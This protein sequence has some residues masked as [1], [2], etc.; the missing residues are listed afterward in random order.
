MDCNSHTMIDLIISSYQTLQVAG[1][2]APP[3]FHAWFFWESPQLQGSAQIPIFSTPQLQ[4]DLV[5]FAGGTLDI[6]QY[7]IITRIIFIT[8]IISYNPW[9]FQTYSLLWKPWPKH[10]S[11]IL[12]PKERGFSMAMYYSLIFFL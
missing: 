10:G 3:V 2:E 5:F 7:F 11:M 6:F 1:Y 12:P 8:R 4:F 9:S